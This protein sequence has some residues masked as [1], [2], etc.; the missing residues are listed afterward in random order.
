MD[1]FTW[2]GLYY[3]RRCT[4]LGESATFTVRGSKPALCLWGDG[5]S[6]FMGVNPS[7]RNGF[8]EEW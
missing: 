6:P 2:D 8:S 3:R 5:A 7:L 1:A 4:E